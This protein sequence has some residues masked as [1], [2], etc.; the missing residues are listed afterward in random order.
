[1]SNRNEVAHYPEIMAFIEK[2]INS[3][4]RAREIQSVSIYWKQGELTSKI[5]EIIKEHPETS[6]C[7]LS[8]SHATPPLNVDIFAIVTDGERFEIVILEIKKSA[9]IGLA[10]WSQLLGYCVVSGAKY[11][12]L[13]NIDGEASDRLTGILAADANVSRVVRKKANGKEVE[14]LLGFMRWNATTKNFEYS[15]L[16]SVRSLSR[17][18]EMLAEHFVHSGTRTIELPLGASKELSP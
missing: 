7:L 10:E 11:G 13:V 17:L 16:G 5:A 4:F 8:Y 15:N 14:H 2:Q 6:D 9:S 1:M 18:S 3:N 12:L